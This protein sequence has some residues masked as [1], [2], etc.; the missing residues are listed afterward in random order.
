MKF[1]CYCPRGYRGYLNNGKPTLPPLDL[2]SNLPWELQQE[3]IKQSIGPNIAVSLAQMELISIQ[4]RN[5]V[6][7]TLWPIFLEHQFPEEKIA[8]AAETINYFGKQATPKNIYR[9]LSAKSVS[10]AL[11]PSGSL[12]QSPEI[13]PKKPFFWNVRN[14][15]MSLVDSWL[16]LIPQ[17][18]RLDHKGI[19][20]SK[21]YQSPLYLPNNQKYIIQLNCTLTYPTTGCQA[22][23]EI[24]EFEI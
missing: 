23:G 12:S 2:F 7:T 15:G 21:K 17:M 13:L 14:T 19:Y 18:T 11:A 9:F 6:I 1:N 5:Y 24:R 10:V 4:W 20:P 8:Y 16:F 3:I 22:S